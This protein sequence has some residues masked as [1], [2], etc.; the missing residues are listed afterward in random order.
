MDWRE[1]EELILA[2]YAAHAA[3]SRGREHTERDDPDR[4]PFQHDRDRIVHCQ[5]FRRLEYKTQVFVNYEGDHYRTRL[6][7]TLEVSQLARSIARRLR[8]NEDLTEAIALAHDLGHTPFGHSGEKSLNQLM[9]THG[10]FEHNQQSLRIVEKLEERYAAFPGLN[11]T[12]EVRQGMM[13]HVTP[14]DSGTGR[15]GRADSLEA[16]VVNL[17]DE[18]AYNSHDLDDGLESGFLSM[19]QLGELAVWPAI[20]VRPR[21]D[22]RTLALKLRRHQVVRSLI[23]LQVCDLVNTAR[24]RLTASAG[25]SAPRIRSNGKKLIAFSPQL[26]REIKQLRRFL[27]DSFYQ[28]YQVKRLAE[29]H[30]R[31]LKQMFKLYMKSPDVMPPR[32]AKVGKGQR[33]RAACDYIAGMTDRYA[34]KEYEKLF[35]PQQLL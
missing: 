15:K 26:G 6:T 2:N 4:S 10:G 11:L 8:L 13:K 34:L 32:F 35:T 16:H 21:A 17:A 3:N 19:D 31:F 22:K 30:D 23:N 7:H 27:Y 33:H 24:Q 1:R 14:W 28:H 18:I 29:K 9:R 25:Q 5:A 12:R 20:Q